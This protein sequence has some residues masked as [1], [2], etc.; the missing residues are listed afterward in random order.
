MRGSKILSDSFGTLCERNPSRPSQP[1]RKTHRTT[2]Y[3]PRTGD[4][5]CSV[6]ADQFDDAANSDRLALGA[7]H[8]KPSALHDKKELPAKISQHFIVTGQLLPSVRK[9]RQRVRLQLS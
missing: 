8:N 2:V 7:L 3:K 1:L 5:A 6:Y 4:I 9:F